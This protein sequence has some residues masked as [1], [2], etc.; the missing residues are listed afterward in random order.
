[1]VVKNPDSRILG[2]SVQLSTRRG[3]ELGSELVDVLAVA[4]RV[5][6]AH[7]APH[8]SGIWNRMKGAEKV[9]R[10][11]MRRNNKEWRERGGDGCFQ[12]ALFYLLPRV[13][14]SLSVLYQN[15]N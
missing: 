6:N 2:N 15:R 10:G 5:N 7:S 12:G 9:R 8:P 13:F 11:E 1:M 3:E 4:K 14:S